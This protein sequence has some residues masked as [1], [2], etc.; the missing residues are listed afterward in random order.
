[1]SY[2]GNIGKILSLTVAFTSFAIPTTAHNIQLAGDVAGTWH[3]EPNHSPKAGET[4]RA[5]VALTR[6]GGKILPLAEADC[7]MGVYSQPRKAGALPVLQPIVQAINVEKYQGIPGTDI[8]LPKTGLYQLELNCQPKNEGDFRAFQLK[9][10]VIVAAG[11]EV[12]TSQ[13]QKVSEKK[14]ASAT[15]QTQGKQN[16]NI[17]VLVLAGLLGLGVVGIVVQRVVKREN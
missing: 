8:I 6:K 3:I 17:P 15:T 2:M 9:Y 13:T 5:W 14:I 4:A 11:A 10:D 16:W 7:Q 12:K 1:M